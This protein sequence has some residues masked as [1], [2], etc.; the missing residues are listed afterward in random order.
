MPSPGLPNAQPESHT[1]ALDLACIELP[2][3]HP[4]AQNIFDMA[5]IKAYKNFVSF[6]LTP[7]GARAASL[8]MRENRGAAWRSARRSPFFIYFVLL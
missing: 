2:D 6:S 8:A 4:H 1:K 7:L 5:V 3:G